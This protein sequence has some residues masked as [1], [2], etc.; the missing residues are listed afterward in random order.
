MLQP[1]ELELQS[2]EFC[3]T[4]NETYIKSMEHT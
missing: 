3:I 4:M 2:M 1:R